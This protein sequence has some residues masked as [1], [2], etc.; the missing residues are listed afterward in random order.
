M[1]K[2]LALLLGLLT[3]GA[4][5]LQKNDIPEPDYERFVHNVRILSESSNGV[6]YEY[7]NVRVDELAILAAMYCND[8]SHKRAFLDKI[9]L[10]N[11]NSRR[12]AFICKNL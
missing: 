9:T 8:Q 4:C 10:H 3:I 7:K 5:S 1:M 12:A 6:V 11:D 2:S